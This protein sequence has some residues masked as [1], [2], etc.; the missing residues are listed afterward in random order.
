MR[1]D[2]FLDIDILEHDGGDMVARN[3][4]D[5]QWLPQ[6]VT[7]DTKEPCIKVPIAGVQGKGYCPTR[8]TYMINNTYSCDIGV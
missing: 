3:E 2:D 7:L 8:G 5:A 4:R 6:R 1:N